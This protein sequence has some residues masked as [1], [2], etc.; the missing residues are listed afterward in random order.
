MLPRGLDQNYGAMTSIMGYLS[1]Y[2]QLKLQGLDKWWYEI[3]AGRV[4]VRFETTNLYF[5]TS[6]NEPKILAITATGECQRLKVS[7]QKFDC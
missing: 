6:S 5:L 1:R 7:Q 4:Q 2:E 3:G